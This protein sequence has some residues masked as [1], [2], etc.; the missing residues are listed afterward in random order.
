MYSFRFKLYATLL[1]T[2]GAILLF[3]TKGSAL[4]SLYLTDTVGNGATDVALKY[5]QEYLAIICGE[6]VLCY[7]YQR[8]RADFYSHVSQLRSG[9]NQRIVRLSDDLRHWTFSQDGCAGSGPG[10]GD[11]PLH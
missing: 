2:G 3:L 1:V 10:Y 8:D 4:I 11:R 7:E 5:G 6:P 9:G